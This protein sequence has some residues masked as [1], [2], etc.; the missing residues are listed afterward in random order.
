MQLQLLILVLALPNLMSC[1]SEKKNI[2]SGIVSV[3]HQM[4]DTSTTPFLQPILTNDFRIW[5]K[6]SMAIE[7]VKLIRF[8][9]DTAGNESTETVVMHYAFIYPASKSFYY[10]KNFSDTAAIIKK[11]A[12]IDSFITDGGWNF[13]TKRNIE[14]TG[15]PDIINDTVIN[16]VNYKRVKFNTQKEDND[17]VSIGYFRCD[18][19]RVIFKFDSDYSEKLGCPLVRIDDLPVEKGNPTRSEL[20]FISDTLTKEELKVFDAWER[21]AKKYPV[22][23]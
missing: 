12:G 22:N 21:N 17:Y 6:D 5:Y 14:Y 9:T 13:Y 18:K 23:L 3:K 4:F 10:Y 11:Y 7:E 2:N 16:Q 20:S 1:S 8:I 15:F 19:K